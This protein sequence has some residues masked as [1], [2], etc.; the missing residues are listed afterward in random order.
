M[1]IKIKESIFLFLIVVQ[2]HLSPFP[3]ITLPCPTK[4]IIFLND[5]IK[6]Y[7]TWIYESMWD[8]NVFLILFYKLVFGI[9]DL[10]CKWFKT[11]YPPGGRKFCF[12]VNL[13]SQFQLVSEISLCGCYNSKIKGQ[14]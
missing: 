2:L 9:Y 4:E 13:I 10:I 3:P 5:F 1:K 6:A 14:K 8:F 12:F 7:C 11:G